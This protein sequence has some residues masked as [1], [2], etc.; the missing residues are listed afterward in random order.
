MVLETERLILR[1]LTPQDFEALYPVL[2]DSDIGRH[3]PY[4]FDEKRVRGWIDRNMQRYRVFGFGLW[5]VVLKRTGRLIG[6]CGLSMQTI[7]GVIRPEIGYHIARAYQRQGFAKEAARM[8]RDWAFAN[9]PFG[10]MDS[11]MKRDNIASQATALANGMRF[12]EAFTDAEGEESVTYRMTRQ[13]WLQN[14]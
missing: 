9:T 7:N 4:T 12:V 2:G 1:Q 3:Y 6:D 10:E 14:R 8:C 5:A 11:C 13:E